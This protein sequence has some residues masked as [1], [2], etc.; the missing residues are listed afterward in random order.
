VEQLPI[1]KKRV[2]RVMPEHHLLVK[3]N[4]K[5]KVKRPPSRS[6]PQPTKPYEWWGI[7]MTKVLVEGFGWVSSVLV[8]DWYTKKSV[9][10][11]AGMPCTARQWLAAL[12]MA[13]NRQFPDGAG[14]KGVALRSDHGY[15]PTAMAYMKA[16]STLGIHQTCTSDHNPKG[17]A[18]TERMMR[19]LDVSGKDRRGRRQPQAVR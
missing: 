3:P 1:N 15:Q 17:N 8:L 4:L 14:G 18:D 9:G 10:Y 11:Y 19:A 6:Q 7:D 13:M 12:E 16:C 5:R 2:L